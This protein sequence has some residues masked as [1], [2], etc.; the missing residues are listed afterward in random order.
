MATSGSVDFS[1]TRDNII[2]EALQ[3][4]GVIGEG[5]T[6]NTNQ[7]TDCARSLNMMIKFWM[8]EGMNLFVN[9]EIVIFAAVF[10]RWLIM[11][12]YSAAL[13]Y[14]KKKGHTM[15]Y[16]YLRIR[17]AEIDYPDEDSDFTV[18]NYHDSSLNGNDI[19]EE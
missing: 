13:W 6:P 18:K 16:E 8:A 10:S 15:L 14:T 3:L 17:H 9:Q 4:V 19:K 1:I 5:D 2:T 11:S 12:G 7:K